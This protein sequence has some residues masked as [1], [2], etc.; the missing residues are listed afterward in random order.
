MLCCKIDFI[1]KTSVSLVS[2]DNRVWCMCDKGSPVITFY[3][4]KTDYFVSQKL[5]F[6]SKLCVK[7]S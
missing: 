5:V 6:L 3:F 2:G 4:Y 1:R 7:F